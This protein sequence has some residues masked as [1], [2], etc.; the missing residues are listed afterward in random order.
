MIDLVPMVDGQDQRMDL[1]VTPDGPISFT[2]EADMAKA[3]K[4]M[5]GGASGEAAG[6][7]VAG[8]TA[9]AVAA[10]AVDVSEGGDEITE[11][12]PPLTERCEVATGKFKYAC[13]RVTTPDG[14]SFVA[15]RS[16]PGMY[17]ADVASEMIYKFEASG[18]KVCEA[19]ACVPPSGAGARLRGA[20][21]SAAM[22]LTPTRCTHPS[23]YSSHT[24]LIPHATH[25]TP[26]THP[27]ITHP[28]RCSSHTHYSSHTLLFPHITHPTHVRAGD[29]GTG[30]SPGRRADRA[31]G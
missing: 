24:L 28:T 22:P 21:P 16:G 13:L 31:K 4:M 29:C 26:I 19:V 17:H 8:G 25:P 27:Q 20:S 7:A 9:A 5:E 6:S 12:L 15:V 3:A 10:A 30:E 18:C 14:T 1:I 11:A 2:S 23:R